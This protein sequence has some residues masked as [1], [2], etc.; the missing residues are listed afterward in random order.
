MSFM[1]A[2][3]DPN[4]RSV[5][6]CELWEPDYNTEFSCWFCTLCGHPATAQNLQVMRQRAVKEA[7]NEGTQQDSP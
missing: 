4:C 2:F 3:P 6:N 1:V 7:S 5:C